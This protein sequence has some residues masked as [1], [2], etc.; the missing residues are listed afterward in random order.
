[1]TK[2]KNRDY[3]MGRYIF[4]M[5]GIIL[6]AIAVAVRLFSTTVIHAAEWEAKAESLN[7]TRVVEP[8][9]G[10]IL[11]DDRTVLAANVNFYVPRLDLRSEGIKEDT[12]MRY[13]KPLCDSLAVISPYCPAVGGTD[14]RCLHSPLHQAWRAQFPHWQ[15]A[16]LQPASAN[17][18]IPIY[19]AWL[20]EERFLL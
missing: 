1:M 5:V 6:V 7:R 3:I 17:E 20:I 13:L 10:K 12:L 14:F 16:H 4:I 11:A 2:R 18:E 19:Q 9:R 15:Q 8:E